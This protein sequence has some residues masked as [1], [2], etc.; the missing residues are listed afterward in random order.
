MDNH[1]NLAFDTANSTIEQLGQPGN[2]Q[3][4]GVG[5]DPNATAPIGL[6]HHSM[7]GGVESDDDDDP[8]KLT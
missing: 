4:T 2:M 5:N 3:M 1:E 8:F 7:S 6:G